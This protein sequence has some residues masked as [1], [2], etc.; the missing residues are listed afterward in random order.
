MKALFL[1][2]SARGD[3]GITSKLIKALSG[4][5]SKTGMET[6][7]IN[8]SEL[9]IVP[10]RAC[11]YCMHKNPG[12]CVLHDEMEI[13]YNELKQSDVVIFG[14]PV[15]LDGITAQLK[16]VIDRLVCCMEPF[17]VTDH[18]G[19]TRHS[20]SWRLPEKFII[21][22]T[23]GFP[24]TDTFNALIDYFRSLSKN[25]NSK[26]LAEFC[27]P[28]SI[29]IQMKPESLDQKLE[30]LESAGYAYGMYGTLDDTII[31]KVNRPLFSK[32]E[33]FELAELYENRCRKKLN[34]LK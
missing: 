23:C 34:P 30:L 32:K 9:K 4:G 15:Y 25:M 21:V 2:G 5:M 28:G 3:K 19:F 10:C 1:N 16:T 20:F 24:E 6:V 29:A 7:S 11:L 33:Y 31:E 13:I 22:S 17:L 26:I 14:S 8:I 18:T 27:I 12:V